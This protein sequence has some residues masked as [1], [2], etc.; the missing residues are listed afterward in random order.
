M[1]EFNQEYEALRQRFNSF[2]DMKEIA[3]FMSEE[4]KLHGFDHEQYLVHLGIESGKLIDFVVPGADHIFDV[5]Q[6][7]YDYYHAYGNFVARERVEHLRVQASNHLLDA[8]KK[9]G[10]VDSYQSALVRQK[11]LSKLNPYFL[12]KASYEEFKQLQVQMNTEVTR[13][14]Q[15]RQEARFDKIEEANRL[16]QKQQDTILHNQWKIFQAVNE[17]INKVT[18]TMSTKEQVE[19]IR[20]LLSEQGITLTEKMEL[21]LLQNAEIGQSVEMVLSML[22][23]AREKEA[24][25][26]KAQQIQKNYQDICSAC[27]FVGELA[28]VV[29]CKELAYAASF[30]QATVQIH[31]AVSAIQAIG[32]ISIGLLNPLS[33]IGMT[34]LN[35][36]SMFQKK[37]DPNKFI[38]RQLQQ[39]SKQIQQLRDE[40]QSHH[41]QTHEKLDFILLTLM[42]GMSHLELTLQTSIQ[43][44]LNDIQNDIQLLTKITESGMH[45]LQLDKLNQALQYIRQIKLKKLPVNSYPA[46]H[47]IDQLILLN[48]F[49]SDMSANE[50]LTGRVFNQLI[51]S[52]TDTTQ[53]K[54]RELFATKKIIH[55]LALLYDHMRIYIKE[56]IF[57]KDT[58]FNPAIWS[59]AVI[60]YCDLLEFVKD[61]INYD[62][63]RIN[64]KDFKEQAKQFL[65]FF[66]VLRSNQAFYVQLLDDIYSDYQHVTKL[67]SLPENAAAAQASSSTS[68]AAN[69]RQLSTAHLQQQHITYGQLDF[70]GRK[71]G[72]YGKQAENFFKTANIIKVLADNKLYFP[73]SF[74]LAVEKGLAYVS[75]NFIGGENIHKKKRKHIYFQAGS[76]AGL[77]INLHYAGNIY[78]IFNVKVINRKLKTG[79]S[80]ERIF[81]LLIQQGTQTVCIP[82]DIERV[83]R[84]IA[85]QTAN[86]LKE[87]AK[88]Q[89][90][91]L[92]DSKEYSRLQ[93]NIQLFIAYLRCAGFPASLCEDTLKNLAI[94]DLIPALTKY[95]SSGADGTVYPTLPFIDGRLLE[96]IKQ[97][98]TTMMLSPNVLP[99]GNLIFSSSIENPVHE[100]ML[101][102]ETLELAL[103]VTDSQRPVTSAQLSSSSSASS[104]AA[105][106]GLFGVT[107][108]LPDSAQR[109]DADNNSLRLQ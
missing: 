107:H 28:S 29:G 77:Q 34:A 84:A 86:N 57:E 30:A 37:S 54:L 60:G 70:A 87:T 35:L 90:M 32:Q 76:S 79:K 33:A 47:W 1:P 101:R 16:S 31:Q 38:M 89:A 15:D 75:I 25:K 7:G 78:P 99:D 96:S 74:L 59:Q 73:A 50:L 10:S 93:T 24:Q 48:S 56:P 53:R 19:H 17:G 46:T 5:A 40:S 91:V 72:V 21:V 52:P 42:K 71:H 108:R 103:A 95:A 67:F 106:V 61:Q 41:Q 26:A 109:H 66:T 36:F 100:A 9:L 49:A 4:A 85:G 8:F 6:A 55:L 65:S 98:I 63:K 82:A 20:Q 104:A 22:I 44:T 92:A 11:L 27:H 80:L 3:D 83:E 43:F 13:F 2:V 102:L 18:G 97:K 12:S 39:I 105:S 51:I 62:P 45:T 58:I 69:L 81:Q 64:L 14:A 68:S 23:V 88:R 94:P